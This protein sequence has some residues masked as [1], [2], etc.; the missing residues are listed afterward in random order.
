MTSHSPEFSAHLAALKAIATD[1]AA[2]N[3]ADVDTKARFPRET[4]DALQKAKLLSAPIPR[5]LGGAGYGMRE[6]AALCS[7]LA[8]ACGSSAMVLAMH[9][10]QVACI[11]RHAKTSPYFQGYLKELVEQQYVLASMTSENGTFGET[12]T[13][14]CAVERSNGRFKLDKDA[15][16]GSYCQHADGI[17]VTCR[18]APDS[19]SSDQVL[20]LVRKGDYTLTQTTSWDT[21]GMRGTCSPGFK[22]E[23]SGAEAQI[24]PGSFADSSAQTMVPYSH[25]LWASLWWG[26]AA[27]AVGRAAEFVRGGARKNPGTV[28]PTATR[29]AE[30]STQL[31]SA[32]H[33]WL[34]LA[35]EF[36]D[37]DARPN[38]LADLLSIG[39]ALKMNNLKINASE[40]APQIVHKALQITGI[41]GYKNDSKFSLG[42][43]YRDSLSGALMISNDRIASKS[44]S[45][46]LVFK[47]N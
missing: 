3:A 8:Q 19:P 4:I 1:V 11:V 33:N 45:M 17:L 28:P 9:Y 18:R 6:L 14:I 23:S 27:D 25:I 22:L 35:T 39:W 2:A 34:A 31:Q 44:A 46:L 5:E 40:T 20:V 32:R 24:I 38:G 26:I 43:H 10:I 16:T 7:T 42:R 12:R 37:I 36:D 41:L 29:L 15:T 30:V 13:S 21:L 47:D